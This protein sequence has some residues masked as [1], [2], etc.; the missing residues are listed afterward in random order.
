MADLEYTRGLSKAAPGGTILG[1]VK[2]R[3]GDTWPWPPVQDVR[4][5]LQG[6]NKQVE[7]KTNRAGK[8]TISG[9]PPGTYKVKIDLTEGLSIYNPEVEVEV[10]DRG[11]AQAFF[12]VEPDTRL[13]GKVLDAQ[14][15]SAADVLM[16]LVPVSREDNGF[17][18]Y[19]RTDKEGRY[20]MKLLK[21][22]RYHLGVRVAGSA[23]STYV[24]FHKLIT[25]E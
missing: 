25:L 21:P 18:S 15:L 8:Y 19:V 12:F 10:H 22:G 13:T 9:L 6:S 17:P 3:R 11:C 20:E 14:G 7:A 16:E 24:P 1:E 5:L 4:I 2:L 23:G